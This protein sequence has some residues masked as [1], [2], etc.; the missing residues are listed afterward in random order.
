VLSAETLAGHR[1]HH[2]RL[3]RMF[4]AL[5]RWGSSS[6]W[7]VRSVYV[8]PGADLVRWLLQVARQR[9]SST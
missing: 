7:L 1:A 2:P 9:Q 8:V 3:L 6:T 4:L 5:N